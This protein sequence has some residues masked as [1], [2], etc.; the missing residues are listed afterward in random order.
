MA[1]RM[2]PM[3]QLN[4]GLIDRMRLGWRLLRD[5]R[6]STLPKVLIPALTALYV[7][8]P[9]DLLPDFLLGI[10]QVDDITVVALALSALSLL[11]RWAPA[12]VVREHASALGLDVPEA[13]TGQP[14]DEGARRGKDEPIEARYW[15]DDWQ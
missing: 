13:M 14:F 3:G 7:V 1:R 10:G 8:S 4:P 5:P 2:R 11:V 9:I 12:Q 6:V 15:V